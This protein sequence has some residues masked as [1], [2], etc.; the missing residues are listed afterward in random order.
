VG[1]RRCAYLGRAV[2]LSLRIRA[3]WQ[4]G[5]GADASRFERARLRASP[6][7]SVGLGVRGG[8]WELGEGVLTVVAPRGPHAGVG[9]VLIVA[10]GPVGA[11]AGTSLIRERSQIA[12]GSGQCRVRFF[13]GFSLVS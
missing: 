11:E 9:L 1:S 2:L 6:R 12:V 8:S 10:L 4:R 5:G 7:G 3:S 13:L